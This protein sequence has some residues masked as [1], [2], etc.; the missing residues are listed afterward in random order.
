MTELLFG[1]KDINGLL[2]GPS[3]ALLTII[4]F[5]VWTFVGYN[6]VIFLAGL[7]SIPKE[8]YEAAE[9]DGA[10]AWGL[11]RHVTIPMISP[12]T[13]YLFLISFIVVW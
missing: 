1:L 2:T 6:T 7:G 4:L 9:M 5:G 12:V 3:L 13:F 8:V 11:F 10:G